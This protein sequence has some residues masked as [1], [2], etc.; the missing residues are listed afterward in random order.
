MIP[1]ISCKQCIGE[2]HDSTVSGKQ[3]S[4][5]VTSKTYGS[6]AFEGTTFSDKVCLD[7]T[8]ATCVA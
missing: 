8:S 4:D 1:D 3:T 2:K 7:T 5:V 6:A